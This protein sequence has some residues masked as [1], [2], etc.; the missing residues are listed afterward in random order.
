ML[1]GYYPAL[2]VNFTNI[3]RIDFSPT[4]LLKIQKS[5]EKHFCKKVD[6]KIL[7]KLTLVKWKI[8]KQQG[9]LHSMLFEF[10]ICNFIIFIIKSELKKSILPLKM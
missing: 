1:L 9:E 2:V 8:V 7:V 4:V 6:H 3:L 10:L 5:F